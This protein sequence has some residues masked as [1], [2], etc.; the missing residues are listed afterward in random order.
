MINIPVK[1][2]IEPASRES[3]DIPV[4][5][6]DLKVEEIAEGRESAASKVVTLTPPEAMFQPMDYPPMHIFVSDSFH[7]FLLTRSCL[8]GSP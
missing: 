6:G 5:E 3:E 2:I 4:D 7:I 1:D 8:K